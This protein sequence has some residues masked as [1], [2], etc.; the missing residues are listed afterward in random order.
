[1]Q[2]MDGMIARLYM[3]SISYF[4]IGLKNHLVER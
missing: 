4:V 2:K 1:M 3:E